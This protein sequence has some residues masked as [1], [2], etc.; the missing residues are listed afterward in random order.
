MLGNKSEYKDLLLDSLAV[1]CNSTYY[2]DVYLSFMFLEGAYPYTGV[3]LV[4]ASVE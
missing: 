1:Q 2:V 3:Y 4:I